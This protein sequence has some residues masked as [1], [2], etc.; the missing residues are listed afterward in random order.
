MTTGQSVPV[1]VC[2]RWRYEP[3]SFL[4]LPFPK[5]MKPPPLKVQNC[6]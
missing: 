5:E 3:F 1:N 4:F 2:F 6:T